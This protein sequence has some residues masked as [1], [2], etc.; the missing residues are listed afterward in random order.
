MGVPHIP[1]SNIVSSMLSAVRQGTNFCTESTQSQQTHMNYQ[2][3][4][5]RWARFNGMSN[6]PCP[7]GSGS[8]EEKERAIVHGSGAHT[9]DDTGGLG[10]SHLSLPGLG[11]HGA[12][13]RLHQVGDARAEP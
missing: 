12:V 7:R 10:L 1:F 2:L 6:G 4:A 9:G 13:G 3:W 8:V 11:K 5:E